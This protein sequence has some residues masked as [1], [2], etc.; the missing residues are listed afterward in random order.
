MRVAFR[1][2][3]RGNRSFFMK[4]KGVGEEVHGR[5][6]GQSFIDQGEGLLTTNPFEGG[7]G[8]DFF[9]RK[10]ERSPKVEPL[11]ARRDKSGVVW[12]QLP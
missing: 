3:A 6:S 9:R 1:E 2:K 7:A 5:L 8:T 4:A 12:S 10:K 11:L